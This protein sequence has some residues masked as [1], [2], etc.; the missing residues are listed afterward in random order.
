MTKIEAAEL[1]SR[2][3]RDRLK[4][5]GETVSFE[6]PELASNREKKI[7][8]RN[9]FGFFW[10]LVASSIVLKLSVSPLPFKRTLSRLERSSA[11]SILI[12]FSDF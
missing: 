1:R 7:S 6:R 8:C 5:N 9:V 12:N 4:G 11:A 2:R 10:R 3:D